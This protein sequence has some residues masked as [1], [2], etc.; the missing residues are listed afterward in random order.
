VRAF[1]LQLGL[2]VCLWASVS[3]AASMTS[4]EAQ[5]AKAESVRSSDPPKFKLLLEQLNHDLDSATPAQRQQV[6][7]LNAYAEAYAGNFDKSGKLAAKLIAET[8]D[9]DLKFRAGMLIINSYALNGNFNEG[10]R[11]M[12]R[13]F[14]LID[15][16]KDN[17]LRQQGLLVAAT[18]YNQLGQYRLG[19]HYAELVSPTSVS[20][21]TACFAA[22]QR[23]DALLHMDALAPDDAALEQAV[24][25]CRSN[26]EVMMA[27]LVRSTLA[28]KWIKQG[29]NDQALQLLQANLGEA[30]ATHYPRLIIEI[31]ALIAQ[32]ELDKGDLAG[33]EANALAAVRTAPDLASPPLVSAYRTLYLIADRRGDFK[34]AL[35][36]Y[37]H[38]ADAEKGYLNEVKTRELAYQI[39]R[40]ENQQ[41]NQQIQLLNRQNNLLQ[42]QQ[43][44]DQQKAANSRMV[45]LFFAIFT[46][47]VALWG[48]KTRRLHA[49]LRRMAET[50]ALTGICNRHHFTALAEQTLAQCARNGSHVALIMLD[51]DHFKSINDNYGHVTGD[52]VLKQVA[53]AGQELCRPVDHFGRLGGEEFAILLNG[54]DL[55][56][57]TRVAEDFRVR[58]GGIQS[59]DSG[60][61]FR[62]SA[63]FGVTCS[64]MAAYDLDKL[65]SQADQM[66]YRAKREGRDRVVAFAHEL[67]MEL[68]GP[69]P[70]P[71]A[72]RNADVIES[73][74]LRTSKA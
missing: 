9:I 6:A 21:R 55:K 50:D 71:G 73:A 56:A 42:L 40:A 39:V 41:K 67:P 64:M 60:F 29:R 66:L 23:F 58:I 8:S 25:Q 3:T 19:K 35:G 43:R 54:C 12:D 70:H 49:S 37:R 38:Y 2:I 52:W 28:Q 59:A 63:S 69:L 61:N 31:R 62:I 45:M 27:N 57:A 24:D 30:L 53:K 4:I 16:V 22:Y 74:S 46:L 47:L 13:T 65:L 26:N 11:Q 34:N 20:P 7:Y 33:A 44:V 14:A 10:L 72:D 5:L 1:A 17:E 15:R 48:Y 51:L 36:Y 32:L 68:R 18:L